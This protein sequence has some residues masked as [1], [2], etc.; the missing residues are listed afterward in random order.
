MQTVRRL[1][2]YAVTFVSLETVLWGAI[3][4]FRSIVVGGGITGGVD[5]LAGALALILVGLPVLLLHG[6][7][8]QHSALRDI[9]ERASR[10]RA[11]FLYGSLLATLI[12]IVQ[13]TLAFVSRSLLVVIGGNPSQALIGANQSFNDNLIAILLNGLAAGCLFYIL[14]SDW[15]ALPQDPDL[16]EVRRLYRYLWLFYTLGLALFGVQQVLKYVLSVPG[17]PGEVSQALLANG[18]A[19]ILAGVP[20]WAFVSRWIDLSLE[21]SGERYSLLRLVVLYI[22][23]LGSMGAA[24]ASAG[25]VLYVGLR[26]LF[27]ESLSPAE[28]LFQ[29]SS[30]FSIG[31]PLGAA[32]A[33]YGRLLYAEMNAF[34]TTSTPASASAPTQPASALTAAFLAKENEK[35]RFLPTRSGLRRL[36]YYLLALGGLA[37]SFVGLQNLLAF[38]LDLTLGQDAVW[39][40]ALRMALAAAIATLAIGLP[41]L[42]LTWR[43][44][45][46]EAEGDGESGDRSRRSVVRKGYLY[47]I[48]FAGVMGVMF[49]TG[50]LLYQLIRSLLGQPPQD[51]LLSSLQMIKLVALFGLLLGY[52]WWVLRADN[53]LASRALARRYAQFPVLIL[54]PD[55][56]DFANRMV[57]AIEHEA[58][59]LPV[60]IH[61]YSQGV[62]DESLSAA[63]AVVLPAELVARPSESIRLWL[64][65]F[66][67]SRVVVPT[68]A[69]G[70]LWIFGG[71]S[72]L[73]GLAR[74]AAITVRRLAEGET[75]PGLRDSS[76]WIIVVYILAGLFVLQIILGIIASSMSLILR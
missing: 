65:G 56:G 17:S 61:P 29:I 42:I 22:L 75:S 57:S 37:A 16:T 50:D 13:N 49:S 9:E 4:L 53:R 73:S 45:V 66:T 76:S 68:P 34:K 26:L 38:F 54:V 51:L 55:D 52:H 2:L 6:W 35:S 28:F 72:S 12:P 46:L 3:S 8:A 36:Y 10:L 48:L 25:L 30:P 1:Y 18:I 47:L 21:E 15:A 59:E 31:L 58:A 71:G 14:R 62:P 33:Y 67:G 69:E 24:L 40:D 19:M 20:L 5:R 63:K 27:G 39:G 60:A 7:L 43:P 44:M 11:I 41:V 23:T 74:Q 64:Q 70:W 32:W